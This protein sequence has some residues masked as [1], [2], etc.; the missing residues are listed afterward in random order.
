[1]VAAADATARPVRIVWTNGTGQSF[2]ITLD[3]A[4]RVSHRLASVAT[5]HPVESGANMSDHIRPEPDRIEIQGIVT[6]TPIIVPSD[7][8]DGTRA[9]QVTVDGAPKTVGNTI[10]RL[11]PIA[12]GLLAPV[13]LPLPRQKAIVLGFEPEFDRVGAVYEALRTIK[14]AGTLVT[15]I[16]LLRTYRNMVIESIDIE[17]S[18]EFSNALP[19][20]IAAKE[21]LIGSVDVMKSP[22][23]SR[24]LPGAANFG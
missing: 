3:A 2:L 6:N 11:V 16:T 20:T 23:R 18:A 8:A 1:M 12:G 7:N 4:M 9:V 17:E 21:I 22:I 14:E 15:I 19:L 5:E 24:S 10:G 13:V